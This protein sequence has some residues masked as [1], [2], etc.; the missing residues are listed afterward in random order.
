MTSRT[1]LILLVF[2]SLALSLNSCR[3]GTGSETGTEDALV[4]A[5]LDSPFF[6]ENANIYFALTDRFFNGDPSNDINFNRTGQTA[7]LRGFEGGDMKGVIQKIEEG[8]FDRLGITAL[9]LTPEVDDCSYS[10]THVTRAAAR[11]SSRSETGRLC[12]G[13]QSRIGR[14]HS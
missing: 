9:W 13:R 8:Y 14:V 2:L 3:P 5:P 11:Y 6:W 1:I 12:A 4:M 10:R 7:T